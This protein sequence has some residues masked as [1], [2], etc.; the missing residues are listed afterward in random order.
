MSAG[1][2]T[3]KKVFLSGVNGSFGVTVASRYNLQHQAR[4]KTLCQFLV[5]KVFLSGV[6]D[7]LA[8]RLRH[9]TICNTKLAVKLC[10]SSSRSL[11]GLSLMKRGNQYEFLSLLHFVRHTS[12]HHVMND[13]RSLHRLPIS[14]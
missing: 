14:A 6:N 9:I 13:V 4:C 10:V 3:K 2:I 11:T 8:S 7:S 5:K 12:A 1:V